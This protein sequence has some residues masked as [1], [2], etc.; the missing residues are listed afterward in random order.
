M[1]S[2]LILEETLTHAKDDDVKSCKCSLR[3]Y[4]GLASKWPLGKL[5][6]NITRVV[7]ICSWKFAIHHDPIIVFPKNHVFVVQSRIWRRQK[8]QPDW[9][10]NQIKFGDDVE[11]Q[12]STTSNK[13]FLDTQKGLQV[14]CQ[15][16]TEHRDL[17][18]ILS[19][20]R[21]QPKLLLIYSLI[22]VVITLPSGGK[23]NEG[24]HLF[25]DYEKGL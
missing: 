18:K 16:T 12:S 17:V 6:T 5:V 11:I 1:Q 15:E 21:L 23:G 25:L 20:M 22:L 19:R 4:A 14:D 13:S 7:A 9:K 3:M 2:S 8:L 24:E 10:K